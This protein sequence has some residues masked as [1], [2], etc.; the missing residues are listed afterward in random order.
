LSAVRAPGD[1][2]QQRRKQALAEGV[3]KVDDRVYQRILA[4]CDE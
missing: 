4:L 3:V 2:S 1:G